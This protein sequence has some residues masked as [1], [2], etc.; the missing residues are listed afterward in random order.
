MGLQVI[1]THLGKHAATG[2]HQ[3]IK[4]GVLRSFSKGICSWIV[5]D[6]KPVQAN[7][8]PKNVV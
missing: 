1:I 3:E 6:F 4:S 8:I 5:A 2:V 7:R